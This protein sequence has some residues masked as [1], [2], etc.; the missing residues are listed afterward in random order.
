MN[1]VSRVITTLGLAGL[2]ALAGTA[3][4][5]DTLFVNGH[6]YTAVPGAPWAEA[7]AV[8]GARIDAV[9]S[10]RGIA[11]L[12]VAGTRIVDLKGRTVIPGIFD[13][14]L[15]M[16]FGA[17]AL[18]GFNLSEPSASLTPEKPEALIERIRAYA[19]S[20]PDD[21]ILFGRGDFSASPP[22]APRHELLDQA[23]SDRPVVIHGS[24]EHSMWLNGR[25][26]EMAGITD[27]P[28]ADPEEERNILRDA[29]GH[30]TG[31]IIEAGMEV[32]E[33]AVQR[34]L[35]AEEQVAML[36]GAL[37]ELN[38]YGIT[39][40]VNAAGDLEDLRRF[41]T[42]RDRGEL[43]VRL[44]SAFGAVAVPHHLTPQFLA[45]L[46]TARATYHDEWLAANLVKFFADG[47]TGRL[48]PLVYQRAQYQTLV[49]ELDRR[50]FQLMT[51]AQ[52]D[53]S[54][55]M[56]L[57]A[58]REAARINGPR[59]RRSRMEHSYLIQPADLPRFAA[60]GVIP[61]LQPIY[62]CAETGEN[63]D[64]KVT[65]AS[66]PWHSLEASGA[67]LAFGSD[68]PCAWPVDPFPNIQQAVMREVFT[69]EDSA[70]VVDQTLNGAMQAGS[71][72][73]GQVYTPEERI[74]VTQAI[75]AYTRNAAYA[76]FRD[77][78]V[79]T[80]EKGKLADLAVLSQDV[81]TV[82]GHGIGRTRVLETWVGGK[83]VYA[84]D[85]P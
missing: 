78:D 85:S 22:F 8:S 65:R 1:A 4:A 38:R 7:I 37:H 15:H 60:E 73:T 52:R 62:C 25:A 35:S 24:F 56:V 3:R 12:K 39:S 83:R 11:K 26:L 49:T 54:V 6:I 68:W 50:G 2:A 32:V 23:V 67:Q 57:D 72:P 74:T 48:P 75:D 84:A 80:L 64:P 81:F 66:D 55:H 71:H 13:S 63:Y 47:S 44:R 33:R 28:V 59:D 79:G 19:R 16:L 5:S 29:S 30:P 21:R 70:G 77:H 34:T 58:Y 69:S 36:R 76:A 10:D 20:H 53:D 17:M 46:E 45:D 14:H 42:L 61:S 18:H 41:G 31:V 40:A 43:T 82:P 51:H 27:Q 9:G